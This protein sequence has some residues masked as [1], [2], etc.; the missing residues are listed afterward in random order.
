MYN[1]YCVS[2]MNWTVLERPA[3]ASSPYTFTFTLQGK[4]AGAEYPRTVQFILPTYI[5]YILYNIQ[6]TSCK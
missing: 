1:I 6:F 3:P 4:S 5:V 2:G